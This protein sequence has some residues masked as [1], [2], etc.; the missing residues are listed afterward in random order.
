MPISDMVA[1]PIILDNTLEERIRD[2]LDRIS[3]KKFILI[4]Y[5][6]IG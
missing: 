3:V 4:S 5:A 1:N 2:A 6:K